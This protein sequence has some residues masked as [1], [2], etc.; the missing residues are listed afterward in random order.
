M[1]LPQFAYR[2]VFFPSLIVLTLLGVTVPGAHATHSQLICN[3]RSLSFGKVITGQSE[4]LAITVSNTGASSV[5]LDEMNVSNPVFAVSNFTGMLTLDPGQSVEFSVNFSPTSVG[6]E[7]A[8]IAFDSTAGT[9][10]IQ[11]NGRG[12]S[13]WGLTATPASLSFGNVAVGRSSTLPLTI[14]NPGAT[15]QTVSVGKIGGA[16]FSVTGITLPLILAGGQSFTFAVTFAPSSAGA[17]SGSILATS[18]NDPSLSIPLS[19]LGLDQAGLLTVLPA[20]INFGSITLGQSAVQNGQLTAGNNSVTVSS[21]TL[22]NPEFQVTGLSL[23]VTIPAGQSVNFTVGF[24]PTGSGAASGTL[25]FGSDATNSPTVESLA[26]IGIPVQY[27]VNLSW[28]ASSSQVVGYNVYRGYQSSGPFAK[29]NS[30][31]DPTTAYTDTSVAGGQ[32]YFYA[33]TAV[34]SGGEES[35]YSNISQ[36][37]IP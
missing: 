34:D 22:S 18:P 8:T 36:A 21:A 12:V 26:G 7:S 25:S 37:V 28:N 5:T 20:S 2:S 6:S 16:G 1:P 17:A 32:T 29:I 31:L 33:T 24:T 23:P 4:T 9:L 27:S 35:P 30:N 15:T 14:N 13:D 3:P 11:A 10:N 19:G